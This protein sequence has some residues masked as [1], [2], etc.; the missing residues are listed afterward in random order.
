MKQDNLLIIFV[1]NAIPGK[2]KTRLAKTM[3]EQKAM[4]VYQQLLKYTHKATHKLPMDKAV[5]Y[6]DSIETDDIWN[7]GDYKKFMQ[8]GS[9]L[10]KRML[11]A[12]K[13]GFSKNYKK[14]IIIGS[15]CPEITSKIITEAFDALPQNN[16]VIGP[17]HDGGYYLL[18]MSSLYAIL[19]KN[20]RWSSDEVLH[21][22]LVDIRN[23]NGSYKLL[24]ELTDVDTENDLMQVDFQFT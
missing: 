13:A 2:V 11:N 9:D 15:D 8:E 17:T 23:M 19:F 3:G 14:V 12:F 20:K 4:E 18:G 1:K 22:T 7:T 21:D 6:S 10:G 24:K 5:Y 16:F